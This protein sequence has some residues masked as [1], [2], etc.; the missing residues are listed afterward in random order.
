MGFRFRKSFKIA[1]GVKL[2]INKKSFGLTIGK[3]GAHYTINSKG[4]RTT[5][6]GIPGTGLSFTSTSGGS[7]KQKAK[8][9]TTKSYNSKQYTTV[10][11]NT[12]N[13]AQSPKANLSPETKTL[14]HY[15]Y[16]VTGIFLIIWGLLKAIFFPGFILFALLGLYLVKKSRQYTTS[17]IEQDN[18][19]QEENKQPETVSNLERAQNIDEVSYRLNISTYIRQLEETI[20]L[21]QNSKNADTV[22]SRLQFL[23]S[24]RD[25]LKAASYSQ[26]DNVIDNINKVLNNKVGLINMAIQRNLDSELEKI[27]ELKTEKGRLNRLNRF[28]EA[29]ETI[30]N[31]PTENISFIEQLK[32]NTKID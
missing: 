29:M 15:I 25:R 24:L 4:K 20:T 5:S 16:L 30:E 14:Y 8:K 21:I 7:K 19:I 2:N 6:I 23:E 1:P 18:T 26:L 28:F 11:H 17:V 32:Q 27:R 22:V 13:I 3:R 31:L 10:T 12:T 9:S